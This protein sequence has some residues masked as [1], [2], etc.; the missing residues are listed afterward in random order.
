MAW[1][2]GAGAVGSV[3]S[4][5]GALLGG[6]GGGKSSGGSKPPKWLRRSTARLGAYGE[7]LAKQPYQ[8]YEGERVAGFS[9]DTMA[10][11]DMIRSNVGAATPAYQSAMNTANGL[12][13]FNAP[14]V[15]TGF[16]S[17][18][19]QTQFDPRLANVNQWA[20]QSL[21]PYMNPYTN[22]VINANQ[23][24]MQNSYLEADNALKS[25]GASANAF[26]NSRFGLAQGQLAAD[27]VRDQSLMSAQ[28]RSQGFNT[29]A[30]LL[31][32]DVDRQNNFALAN[33]AAGI[34]ADQMGLQGQLA[35]QGADLTAQGMGLQGQLANQSGALASAGVR[36]NA[37]GQL[38]WLGLG[39][40]NSL[41]N[42]ASAL[43]AA[44]S[45]QQALEQ[46]GM[47]VGYGDYRDQRD[48]A[49]NQL[50]L[51]SNSLQPGIAAWSGQQGATG[52]GI[53]GMLGGAQ[54]GSQVGGSIY[55]WWK[56]RTP[57]ASPYSGGGSYDSYSNLDY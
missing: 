43:G 39:Y 26:G 24:D 41:A 42:D 37:A 35:N 55:D 14:N 49:G 52:G 36:G 53:P 54:I 44:G 1:I 23:S 50:G 17:Q 27:S 10:A 21:D 11:F 57:A 47:D 31:S 30:G 12:S 51:W 56:N 48:W 46:Q 18:Q 8:G 13:G 5:A 33:Q 2:P 28:L 38:G 19:V 29:A 6:I 3:M 34:T 7:E 4:G 25:Q 9:P 22:S 15:G 20:G 45:A 16:N 40:Q 32:N